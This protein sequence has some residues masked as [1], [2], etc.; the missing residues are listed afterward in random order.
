MIR[1]CEGREAKDLEVKVEIEMN[2]VLHILN[3]KV[4]HEQNRLIGNNFI[5]TFFLYHTFQCNLIV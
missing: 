3:N 2:K 1:N 5:C 4:T